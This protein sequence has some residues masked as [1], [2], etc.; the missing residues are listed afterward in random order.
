MSRNIF[1]LFG[2][3]DKK[4]K[5][6][7]FLKHPESRFFTFFSTSIDSK[8]RKEK[9]KKNRKSFFTT[10]FIAELVLSNNEK[11]YAQ[12]KNLLKHIDIL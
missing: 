1:H 11:V 4:K 2:S 12:I 5:K 10:F 7:A 3:L 6:H 8:K 9:T